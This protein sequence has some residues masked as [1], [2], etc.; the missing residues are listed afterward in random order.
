MGTLEDQGVSNVILHRATHAPQPMQTIVYQVMNIKTE[1]L[2]VLFL[3]IFPKVSVM[4]I[5]PETE[6]V[7]QVRCTRIATLKGTVRAVRQ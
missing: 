3:I 1:F 6:H 2:S 4:P 5:A 7:L